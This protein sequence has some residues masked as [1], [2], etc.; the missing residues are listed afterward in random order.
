M[1][2]EKELAYRY[3]LFVTP[4]W[5]DRFDTMVT[6]HIKIPTEGRIL[7]VNCGTGA[8][9]IEI[10]EGLRSKGEVTGVDSSAARIEI[11]R[12]KA[13]VKKLKEA[14]FEQSLPYDLR[15][16]SD[17]FD[18]VIGDASLMPP[19]EVEDVLVEMVR[20]AAEGG[21]VVFKIA[22][23]GSFGEF[24]SIFWEALYDVGLD[25]NVWSDLEEL[26]NER[27]TVSDVEQMA[28]RAGLRRIVSF[29][30]REEFLFETGDQ[31]LS[32]P[33]IADL[34]L[35]DWLD[36]IPE[37]RRSEISDRIEEIIERERNEGPFDLSIKATIVAGVK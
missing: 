17:V 16:E 12:A 7:D 37:E 21:R 33:L 13:Q 28:R 18:V 34:F 4:D 8:H 3:D 14:T 19:N 6:E 1:N 36:I 31:F 15:F 11:A 22:T 32:S 26:V 10:A 5:R 20:V 2:D 29:T 35:S 24:F 25:G 30:S 9:A 27:K 23:H